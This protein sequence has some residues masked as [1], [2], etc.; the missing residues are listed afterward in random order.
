MDLQNLIICPKCQSIHKRLPLKKGEMARCRECGE[1]LYK[2][3]RH[4][5]KFYLSFSFTSL[6]FFVISMFFPIVD[7][8]LAGF[9]S[10]LSIVDSVLS[11]FENGYDLVAI[12][13]AFVLVLFPLLIISFLF[14]GTLLM[15]LSILKSVVKWLLIVVSFL[16]IWSMLD[17]FFISILVSAV[18]IF[19]YATITL[20]IAFYSMIVFITLELYLT[21]HRRIEEL[22]D[23]YEKI[24]KM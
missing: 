10:S 2:D 1:V 12:F 13:S 6:V 3:D 17:I 19:D 11:L 18:K 23:E 8:N 4:I 24:Y 22:W 15:E 14:L 21:K 16:D 20:D 5:L 7:I 9:D